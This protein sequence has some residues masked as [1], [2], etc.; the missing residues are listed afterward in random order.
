MQLFKKC[1]LIGNF[2]VPTKLAKPCPPWFFDRCYA[3]HFHYYG[4]III[5]TLHIK[6]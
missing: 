3:P 1:F 6:M 2:V 4:D 5:E